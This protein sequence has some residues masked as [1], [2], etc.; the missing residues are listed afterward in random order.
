M[1]RHFEQHALH[2]RSGASLGPGVSKHARVPDGFSWSRPEALAA[3]IIDDAAV[4][5]PVPKPVAQIEE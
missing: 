2:A 1:Y 5:S 3:E 4:V